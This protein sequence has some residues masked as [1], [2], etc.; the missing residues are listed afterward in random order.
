MGQLPST[1]CESRCYKFEEGSTN[2]S[3][4]RK[5]ENVRVSRDLKALALLLTSTEPLPRSFR[6]ITTHPWATSPKTVGSLCIAQVAVMI[7]EDSTGE[8][9][10]AIYSLGIVD[11]LVGFLGQSSDDTLHASAISLCLLTEKFIPAA[12][13]VY[14][15]CTVQSLLDYIRR[16]TIPGLKLT[17][18]A[19]LRNIQEA[20]LQVRDSEYDTIYTDLLLILKSKSYRKNASSND[21]ILESLQVLSDFIRS[22]YPRNH[23]G[24]LMDFLAMTDKYGDKDII[25]ESKQIK[26]L[27]KN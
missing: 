25:E 1:C 8:L 17:L 9:C 13:R 21:V 2:I 5:F 24:E 12:T 23:A 4:F 26:L 3:D 27:L 18:I 20:G 16:I 22:N 7:S 10:R 15:I 11:I 19:I 14:E 6:P